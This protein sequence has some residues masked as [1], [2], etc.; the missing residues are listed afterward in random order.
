MAYFFWVCVGSY[1]NPKGNGTTPPMIPAGAEF[2]FCIFF[3]IYDYQAWIF[4]FDIIELLHALQ[5]LLN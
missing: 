5:Q 2:N 3:W 4:F 1:R